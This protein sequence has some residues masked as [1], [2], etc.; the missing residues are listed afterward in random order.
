MYVLIFWAYVNWSTGG[1]KQY[2]AQI[3][4]GADLFHKEQF[5]IVIYLATISF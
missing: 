4:I 5:K 1:V 3:N 2:E